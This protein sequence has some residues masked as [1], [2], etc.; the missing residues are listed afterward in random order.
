MELLDTAAQALAENLTATE[1]DQ[2]VGQLVA[3]A[4]RIHRVPGAHESQDALAPE[5]T[6]RDHHPERRQQHRE[7]EEEHLAVDAAQE[8]HTKRHQ[9]DHDES[10]HV[11]L[12]QQQHS[13]ESQRQRHR[14][15]RLDEPLLDVH[16]ANHVAGRVHRH[17]QLG[18]F[19]GLEI[20]HAQGQPTPRTVDTLAHMRN[21]HHG[22]QQQRKHKNPGRPFFP[23]LDRY[24]HR[25]Q[26]SHKR[27]AQRH[28][29][30]VE[31]EGGR[32]ARVLGAVGQ[33]HTGRIDHHQT[34]GQQAH[35]APH[36][37]RV[38]AGDP[39]RLIVRLAIPVA[40]R[41]AVLARAAPG[42]Q[43]LQPGR[44][45]DRLSQLAHSTA[46]PRSAAR[47]CTAATNTSARWP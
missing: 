31:K 39:G 44:Q 33:R 47:A 8:Q 5:R 42:L 9:R 41:Q 40:N 24:L 10:A 18:Q 25:Q 28:R 32:I 11:R 45:T 36:Q 34:Q 13:D 35:H 6:G 27:D 21:Q 14:P 3:L 37:R 20:H 46:S 16:L 30:A 23:C 29:M 12:G 15:H 43:A 2:R 26:R 19:A 7:A 1:S 22:E 17:T 4:C 38:E